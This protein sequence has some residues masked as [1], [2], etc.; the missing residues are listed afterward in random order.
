MKVPRSDICRYVPIFRWPQ[1]LFRAREGGDCG[2]ELASLMGNK[3]ISARGIFYQSQ[4]RL[5]CANIILFIYILDKNKRVKA[6]SRFRKKVLMARNID[7]FW[8][9]FCRYF[10]M[11]FAE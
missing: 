5:P 7:L 3:I 8:R 1:R 9:T 6:S 11:E 10:L 2:S 4:P